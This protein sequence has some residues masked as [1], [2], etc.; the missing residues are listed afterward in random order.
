M[1]PE[2]ERVHVWGREV[3]VSV[4]VCPEFGRSG[5]LL[6]A[7]QFHIPFNPSSTKPPISSLGFA[8]MSC[9][10]LLF[11]V[12]CPLKASPSTPKDF[13]T[14]KH[15]H[16]YNPS[17]HAQQ[18][19]PSWHVL[20][21]GTP[22]VGTGGAQSDLEGKFCFFNVL[23]IYLFYVFVL[24]FVCFSA[25]CSEIVILACS[26]GRR[27]VLQR[28]SVPCFSPLCS[29]RSVKHTQKMTG[30]SMQIWFGW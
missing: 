7:T 2:M 19:L 23:F 9:S 10:L 24:F 29:R 3:R 21:S 26:I 27:L 4:G 15:T 6:S 17:C 16:F 30:G 12:A 1:S 20:S 18:R 14:H 5:P 22:G 13:H 25:I 28:P 11:P 8:Y